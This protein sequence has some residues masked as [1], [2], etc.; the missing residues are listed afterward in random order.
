MADNKTADQRITFEELNSV[1]FNLGRI[2]ELSVDTIKAIW[3]DDPKSLKEILVDWNNI[4]NQPFLFVA[5][6]LRGDHLIKFLKYYNLELDEK[7]ARIY[8]FFSLIYE[9]LGI[10]ESEIV[11]GKDYSKRIKFHQCPIKHYFVMSDDDKKRLVE[12]GKKYGVE[13]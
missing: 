6:R 2:S 9:K 8:I 12:W 7:W 1:A 3:C 5:K 4:N 10:A 13:E 11:F